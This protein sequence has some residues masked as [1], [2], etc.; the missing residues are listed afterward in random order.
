MEDTPIT[1]LSEKK[2]DFIVLFEAKSCNVHHTCKA[3]K[4]SKSSYYD[5]L[6]SDPLFEAAIKDAYDGQIEIVESQLFKNI[7]QG[8]ET[9]LMFFLQNRAPERWKDRR[10]TEITGKLILV[11]ADK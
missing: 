8:K 11:E 4:M 7:L 6:H 9:S 3:L 2:K 10:T 1:E 5:W